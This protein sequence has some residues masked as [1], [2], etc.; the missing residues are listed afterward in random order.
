MEL[1]HCALYQQGVNLA[2]SVVR[3]EM[4][5]FNQAQLTQS[6]SF[7]VGN[8]MHVIKGLC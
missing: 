5:V 6:F 8:A 3:L 4:T 2:T 1:D 7:T